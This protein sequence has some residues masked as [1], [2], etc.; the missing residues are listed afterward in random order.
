M[1]REYGNLMRGEGVFVPRWVLVSLAFL[2]MLWLAARIFM[3]PMWVVQRLDAPD[4][5]R[6]ARLMRSVHTRH[7]FVVQL[8]DGL[9]WQTAYYSAPLDEDF[10]IDLGERLRWSEDGQRVYFTLQA[11]PVWA[12]D[13]ERGRPMTAAEWGGAFP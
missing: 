12:Y 7:H 5:A 8:K 1:A 4:G 6:S 3:P 9:R 11:E 13:F 10:R 2:A